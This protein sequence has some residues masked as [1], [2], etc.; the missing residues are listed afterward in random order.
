[1]IRLHLEH[2]MLFHNGISY[3]IRIFKITSVVIWFRYLISIGYSLSYYD[4]QI[5]QKRGRL[6]FVPISLFPFF[7][8][9][10]SMMLRWGRILVE[11]KKI[12]STAI[13]SLT[14]IYIHAPF[15]CSSWSVFF[16][17][18]FLQDLKSE[19]IW[20]DII[21]IIRWCSRNQYGYLLIQWNDIAWFHKQWLVPQKSC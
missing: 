21:K 10:H 3:T 16:Q 15:S 13:F 5:V 20:N 12:K 9:T 19:F 4:L 17:L 7:S 18:N 11:R 8:L 1:M 14:L 6:V 2:F